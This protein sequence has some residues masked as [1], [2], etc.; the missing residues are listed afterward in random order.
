MS[1][2]KELLKRKV[3]RV[4]GYR[5]SEEAVDYFWKIDVPSFSYH[6]KRFYKEIDLLV[7]NNDYK[8]P[9]LLDINYVHEWISEESKDNEKEVFQNI[10]KMII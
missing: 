2:K 5:S 9:N 10:E 3:E 8:S 1:S 7:D 4:K 6:L